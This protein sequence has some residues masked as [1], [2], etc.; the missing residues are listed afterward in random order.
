MGSLPAHRISAF[1]AAVTRESHFQKWFL[2]KVLNLQSETV[3]YCS[4]LQCLSPKF[5]NQCVVSAPQLAVE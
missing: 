4:N 5:T 3:A 2:M 1:L